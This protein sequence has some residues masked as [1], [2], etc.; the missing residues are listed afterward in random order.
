MIPTITQNGLK[1]ATHIIYEFDG[2]G[3]C[4]VDGAY[5]V[6][7]KTYYTIDDLVEYAN[8]IITSWKRK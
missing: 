6:G 8:T 2:L 1:W 4:L 7:N 3:V 5:Q